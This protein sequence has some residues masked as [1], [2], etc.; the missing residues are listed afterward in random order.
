MKRIFYLFALLLPLSSFSSDFEKRPFHYHFFKHAATEENSSKGLNI[1]LSPAFFWN[2]ASIEFEYPLSSKFS[3][4]INLFAKLGNTGSGKNNI[5][6]KEESFLK[7]GYLA[8]GLFRFYPLAMAPEGIF[9]QGSLTYG[10]LIYFD[11]NTRPY[12]LHNHWRK[13]QNVNSSIPIEKPKPLGG[14]LGIGF[15]TVII[16]EHLIGCLVLGVQANTDVANKTFYSIYLA[17]SLGFKF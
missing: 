3:L 9:I 11:G 4:G 14:G 15:Q 1:K 2:T 7:D 8:E 10:N 17:P 6:V 13:L 12:T 5:K 16:P